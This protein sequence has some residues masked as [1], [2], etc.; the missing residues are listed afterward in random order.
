V[1]PSDPYAELHDR[2]IAA[3]LVFPTPVQGLYGRSET[4]QAVVRAIDALVHRWALEL[5]ATTIYVPPVL[6][7][8][9][10]DATNYLQSF[11]D[12]MGSVHVF[13]G[14]DREH[15]ELV[16]R[17]EDDGD[18]QA[19]LVPGEVVLSSAA[20]HALYPMITGRLPAGGRR[21]EVHGLCFRHEPSIDPARMQSFGMHEVVY[22]GDPETAQRHRDDGLQV[23]M[24]LLRSLGLDVDPVAANDPFFGRLGTVLATS[25]LEEELKLEGVTPIFAG[26]EPTAIISGNCHRDHFGQP[27][28]IETESGAVAHS[29]CVAFGVDRVAVSLFAR[30]GLDPAQWSDKAR[31]ALFTP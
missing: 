27:F 5:E 19:L 11:P 4:Y 12:L 17:V 30:H 16:R 13:K 28:G 7:R 25:Q 18:W 21:F 1:I 15:A 3:Q 9:T 24:N 22:V 2:M 8:S 6:A 29:A 26:K 14:T 20:C 31:A 23:G 10:F